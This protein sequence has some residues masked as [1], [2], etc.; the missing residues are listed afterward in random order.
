M[1]KFGPH[2]RTILDVSDPLTN[3]G[4]AVIGSIE[5]VPDPMLAMSMPIAAQLSIVSNRSMPTTYFEKKFIS[6]DAHL[7]SRYRAL[8][9][10]A[11]ASP[12][13]AL[14]ST[15]MSQQHVEITCLKENAGASHSSVDLGPSQ[16]LLVSV[17][18]G[19]KAFEAACIAYDANAC[20]GQSY[21]SG[22]SGYSYSWY[23]NNT[24]IATVSGS[25]INP[26]GTFLGKSP[27]TAG[28]QG[29]ISNGRNCSFVS[30][31]TNNV[32][33]PKSLRCRRAA[34]QRTTG[35]RINRFPSIMGIRR[36]SSGPERSRFDAIGHGCV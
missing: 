8:A 34:I 26:T 3:A 12:S 32:L 6:V 2:S 30:V 14:L 22:G 9:P 28:A 5:L 18:G 29:T 11:L 7:S 23:S 17:C 4:G 25:S 20:T 16:M 13:V 19:G 10:S 1:I 21:G 31:G 15:S 33:V 24:A 36:R 35:S 27:G